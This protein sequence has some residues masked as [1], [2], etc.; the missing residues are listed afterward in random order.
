MLFLHKS[1]VDWMLVG[2]GNPGAEY[3]RSRHNTGFHALDRLAGQLGAR[4]EK[5]KFQALYTLCDYHGLKLLLLKPQTYMNES[6]LAVRQAAD[7]YHLPPEHIVVLFDDVSLPVGR[8]RV[9]P[10][11]SAGGHNGIKS[12]IACLGTDVF[13]RV[14]IGVGAKPR[15][16]YDLADWVLGS[17]AKQ[18]LPDYEDSLAR[19]ADAALFLLEHG[20]EETEA[21]FNGSGKT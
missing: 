3:D 18:D 17:L 12:I 16:D 9:R 2:L 5:K 4:A 21:K 11:G 1:A 8:I 6:G 19:A 10:K 7:F 15:P 14:K 13:P 20:C